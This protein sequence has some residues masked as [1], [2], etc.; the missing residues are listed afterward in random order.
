VRL[1]KGALSALPCAALNGTWYRCFPLAFARHQLSLAY[2]RT[3]LSRFSAGRRLPVA[4][5]YELLY[6]AETRFVALCEFRA[7]VGL[8]LAGLVRPLPRGIFRTKAFHATIGSVADLA[9]VTRSQLP[10]RTGAQELTGDW[11]A[12][13]F[14]ASGHALPGISVPTP[15]GLAPTQDLGGALFRTPGVEGFTSLSSVVPTRRILGIF[16][17]KLNAGSSVRYRY[18]GQ[19]FVLDAA[20]LHVT[21]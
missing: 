20:G 17:A 3:A 7:L 18:G 11:Q 14:R 8:P 16:P 10:L 6:L 21:P 19:G 12:N 15:T 13:H 9:D 5:Q 2:S 4:D 1:T